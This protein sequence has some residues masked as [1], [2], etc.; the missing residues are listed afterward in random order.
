MVGWHHRLIRHEFEQT[1]GDDEEQGRLAC[2]SPWGHKE[3]DMTEHL[4]NN[5]KG[6][7]NFEFSSGLL[8]CKTEAGSC[9]L[10]ASWGPAIFNAPTQ[11]SPSSDFGRHLSQDSHPDS[12]ES[13]YRPL[14]FLFSSFPGGRSGV[15]WRVRLAF[16]WG[17]KDWLKMDYLAPDRRGP[18]YTS[19][20]LLTSPFFQYL[21]VSPCP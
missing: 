13:Y 19:C 11:L 8:T 3:S 16:D 14:E 5:N 1:L 17:S 2:C 10:P 21:P 7:K 9:S 12:Q 15:G 20:R 6:G 18:G 4:N